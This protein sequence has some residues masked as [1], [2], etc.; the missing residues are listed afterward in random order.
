MKG[1]PQEDEEEKS[2]VIDSNSKVSIGLVIGLLSFVS[3]G[4]AIA[5]V[6]GGTAYGRM[7]SKL[8]ALLKGQDSIGERINRAED[9]VR[10]LELHVQ[11]AE[12]TLSDVDRNGT[13][14]LKEVTA[15]VNSL[16][17]LVEAYKVNGSP[18]TVSRINALEQRIDKNERDVLIHLE[19]TK[20]K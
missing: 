15:K 14:A 10:S 18:A 5:L 11:K 7:D 13:A 2:P 4:G 19:G 6:G 17:Q 8:E 9:L 3:I 16:H 1:Y 12:T 20:P